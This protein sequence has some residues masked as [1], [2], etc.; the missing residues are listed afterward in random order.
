MVG[1]DNGRGAHSLCRCQCRHSRKATA[2]GECPLSTHCGHLK[3]TSC[4]A[5]RLGATRV[6]LKSFALLLALAV[7]GPAQAQGPSTARMYFSG[8]SSLTIPLER[9]GDGKLYVKAT[10]EGRPM[11]LI[12]DTGA[13]TIVDNNILAGLG[14]TLAHP[15]DNVATSLT[16]AAGKRQVGTVDL[17]LGE[18]VITDLLV[19]GLDLTQARTALEANG[20]P[21]FAGVLGTDVLAILRAR[22]D[23]ERRTLSIKRPDA[24][25]LG[26]YQSLR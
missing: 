22:I 8:P 24:R 2:T 23:Y 19:S 4:S 14:V 11:S 7:T 5:F 12:V 18:M 17:V 21:A 20:V 13:T 9:R 3:F 15:T 6:F 25:S 1:S 26:Q 16:G 10:I